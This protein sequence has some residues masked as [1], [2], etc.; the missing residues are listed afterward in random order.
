ML[1]AGFVYGVLLACKIGWFW[2][3]LGV[4]KFRRGCKH[5][6]VSIASFSGR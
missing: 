3:G 6:R 2:V 5:F 4:V 1:V